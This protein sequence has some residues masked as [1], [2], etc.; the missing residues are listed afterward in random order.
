[1]VQAGQCA[2]FAFVDLTLSVCSRTPAVSCAWQS[3]QE[4]PKKI[5]VVRK[6][7]EFQAA[8]EGAAGPEGSKRAYLSARTTELTLDEKLGKIQVRGWPR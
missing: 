6:R 1:M 2:A 8:P 7:E 3:G 5:G 4:E